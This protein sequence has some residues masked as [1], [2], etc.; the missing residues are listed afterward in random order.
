MN[1]QQATTFS[2]QL[3]YRNILNRMII[4][5][6][7]HRL[8]IFSQCSHSLNI[9]TFALKTSLSFCGLLRCFML[10]QYI[11]TGLYFVLLI[12]SRWLI[13]LILTV[14]R[15]KRSC[16]FFSKEDSVFG[17]L[18][19]NVSIELA[20]NLF[21]AS[22]PQISARAFKIS[23]QPGRPFASYLEKYN[24]VSEWW[25]ILMIDDW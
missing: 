17:V 20:R 25:Y 2:Q 5:Y 9:Y 4:N 6:E 7:F 13:G 1:F 11:R 24:S 19:A 12:T 18:F 14:W 10:D 16:A 15:W 3:N 23:L 8:V 21:M 22:D